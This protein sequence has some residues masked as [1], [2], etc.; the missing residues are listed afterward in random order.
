MQ[1]GYK[2]IFLL[3]LLLKVGAQSNFVSTINDNDAVDDSANT[4]LVQ[5]HST[6]DLFVFIDIEEDNY[7]SVPIVKRLMVNYA[8]QLHK[9]LVHTYSSQLNQL[10]FTFHS[11]LSPPSHLN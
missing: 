6:L 7:E 5:E 10:F 3:L 2:L 4:E 9:Y 1:I 8:K 11:D